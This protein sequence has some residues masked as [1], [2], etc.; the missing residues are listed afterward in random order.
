MNNRQTQ[1]HIDTV[2]ACKGSSNALVIISCLMCFTFKFIYSSYTYFYF[3][4][5]PFPRNSIYERRRS[6]KYKLSATQ[7]I[8]IWTNEKES[9]SIQRNQREMG[10]NA[11]PSWP[12]G[13]LRIRIQCKRVSLLILE[14]QPAT[15]VDNLVLCD[16]QTIGGR[17]VTARDSQP[18]QISFIEFGRHNTIN[19]YQKRDNFENTLNM[20]FLD[21][22]DF[23]RKFLTLSFEKQM[24]HIR[25]LRIMF[26]WLVNC[27]CYRRV[28]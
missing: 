24:N 25:D 5:I 17:A 16:K 6:H 19:H 15:G 27:S 28:S 14:P 9:E 26:R 12:S 1:S 22:R 7:H 18:T 21:F 8:V 2:D 13:I 23:S 11:N 3:F 4:I 20:L 10:M